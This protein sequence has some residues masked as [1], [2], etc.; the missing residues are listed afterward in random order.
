MENKLKK[1]VILFLFVA[2]FIGSAVWMYQKYVIPNS[3][4]HTELK[5]R[6]S[7]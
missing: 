1:L 3:P 5:L 7:R 4:Y 2:I 6:G